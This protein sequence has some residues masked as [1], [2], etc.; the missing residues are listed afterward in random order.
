M[1]F[2]QLATNLEVIKF[3]IANYNKKTKIWTIRIENLSIKAVS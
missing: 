2:I 1:S 3:F